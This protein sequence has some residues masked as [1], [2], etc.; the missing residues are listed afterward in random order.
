M[1]GVVVVFDFDKTIIDVDSDNWVV[2]SLGFTEPFERLLPTMPW[3]TLMDTMMGELH[4]HGR[5]LDDVAE[6]LRAAPVVAG[7]PAAI[8]AAY[9]LG[10]DLRV[11]SDANAFF[12]DTVLA[13]HGLLGCFSQINTNPSH[14]D[15]DADGRLRIG[16]Y[17]DLHGCG[18]GTCPPNMCKG[19]V[20]DRILR[21]ASSSAAGRK[22]V[23]Y[24]GDGRGDYCPA[25]RLAREDFVMPR[26]GFPV[27][28]LICE[29][30]ARLQAE[31]HP[32]ADGAELEETLLRLVGRARVEEAALLPPLDCKLESMP[33]AAQEGM[34]PIMPLGVKH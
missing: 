20:L 5:T 18:V 11:L 9:A 15:A 16:P 33:V 26:R 6:A 10:C 8:K 25:L 27:W 24:L 3:N 12:I 31:V 13:H 14:P 22:R 30:P 2:D 17:H 7:V 21:E 28:D 1:A 32:W 19:Q 29:D 4:A 34:G 23:V